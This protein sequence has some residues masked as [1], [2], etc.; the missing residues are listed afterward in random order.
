[1]SLLQVTLT[2]KLCHL[3]EFWWLGEE[4]SLHCKAALK[5]CPEVIRFR[6]ISLPDASHTALP[7]IKEAQR[8]N[9]TQKQEDRRYC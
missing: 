3:F 2:Q 9:P 8:Y 7:H 1:M 5:A 4:S 6:Y